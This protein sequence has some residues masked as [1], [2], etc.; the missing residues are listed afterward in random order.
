MRG[1]V[2][3]EFAQVDLPADAVLGRNHLVVAQKLILRDR[4]LQ[5]VLDF[6]GQGAGALG[7]GH[8]LA[9]RPA[10]LENHHRPIGLELVVRI[11]EPRPLGHDRQGGQLK[12]PLGQIAEIHSFVLRYFPVCVHVFP[13]P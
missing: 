13:L 3:V 10:G 9:L 5:P 1:K 12:I 2:H 7:L 11:P 8:H 4:P 6:T